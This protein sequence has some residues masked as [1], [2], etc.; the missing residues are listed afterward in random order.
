MVIAERIAIERI[1]IEF[2]QIAEVL[3]GEFVFCDPRFVSEVVKLV[4]S[5]TEIMIVT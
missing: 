5:N 1:A 2:M 3:R 4:V